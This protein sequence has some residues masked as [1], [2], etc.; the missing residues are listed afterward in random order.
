MSI[1][2]A[3]A[4]G[5]GSTFIGDRVYPIQRGGEITPPTPEEVAAAA[6]KA[7][8]MAEDL[9]AAQPQPTPTQPTPTQPTPTQPTETSLET[10]QPN[11][12]SQ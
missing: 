11:N 1:V 7:S 6:L 10:P 2:L 8:Q 4:A 3:S 9:A 12:P 5:I